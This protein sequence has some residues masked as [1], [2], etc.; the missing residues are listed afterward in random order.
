ML[1]QLHK[2]PFLAWSLLSLLFTQQ[3]AGRVYMSVEYAV[4]I[5]SAMNDTEASIADMIHEDTGI[6]TTVRIHD[7]AQVN[8]LFTLGYGA[9]FISTEVVDGDTAYFSVQHDPVQTTNYTQVL[10][11]P[12]HPDNKSGQQVSLEKWF[13]DFCFDHIDLSV[14]HNIVPCIIRFPFE[15]TFTV[16]HLSMPSPP[17]ECA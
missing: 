3:V 16:S 6:E 13:P 17:P 15:A 14:K 5:E 12:E 10:K 7:E 1:F 9:P 2:K 8:H 4:E 11:M